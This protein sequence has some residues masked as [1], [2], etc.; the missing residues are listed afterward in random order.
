MK[1]EKI[2]ISRLNPAEYN[3]RLELKAGDSEYEK[4][5]R[6]IVE[7]GYVEPII[8]NKTTGNI[9]GGHQRFTVLKDLGHSKVDCVVVELDENKEKALNIALNKVHGSWNDDK[10]SALLTDL[11]EQDFDITLTGFELSEV[12][13]LLDS[14]YSSEAVQDDFDT[15]KE[16]EEIKAKG[17]SIKQGEIWQLGQH[18]LMCGDSTS[19]EDMAKLM[20][21]KKAQMS[22][23]SPPPIGQ[24]DY[25][26]S[27]IEKW[28]DNLKATIKHIAKHTQVVCFNILDLY[29]TGTQFIEPTQAY[30]VEVFAENGLRPI[31]V[32]VWKKANKNVGS[33]GYH[34]AS[35]K[36]IP[37]YEYVSAYANGNQD[38][39]NDQ[40]YTWLSTFAG[41]SYKFVKRLT[42][43]E[44]KKWGYSGVWE[45]QSVK[46][47][48]EHGAMHPV[49]LP[50]RCIK[51][52]SDKGEIVLEPF[53]RSGTTII[54]SEQIDR[55]CY[56]ME[57]DP[58]YVELAIKRWE[59]FTGQKA[60]QLC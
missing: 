23:T 57:N 44:R 11:E 2:E 29:Q 9:V 54:A 41:H 38:E 10:L 5:K 48:K 15:D 18:R 52:H 34:L 12:E 14:F 20:N 19:R 25:A 56:A 1:I 3:P 8:W 13:E 26:K 36:P 7:F 33:S 45:M 42:K 21:G 24:K 31:W 37:Q 39:Y 4:L 30:S 6:S 27:G 32:R 46:G 17:T 51:M 50:W 16:S 35:N 55:V 22:F 53:S 40:E 47:S 60:V 58:H 43:E 59:E 28:K 49:E